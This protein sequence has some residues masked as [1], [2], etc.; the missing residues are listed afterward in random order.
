V[1]FGEWLQV[2]IGREAT[3][4]NTRRQDRTALVVAH[5][6]TSLQRLLDVTTL[7]ETDQRVQ[8]VF[9]QGPGVFAAAGVGELLEN[10]GAAVVPWQQATQTS[11]DVALASGYSGLAELHAPIVVLPHGAGYNKFVPPARTG[12]LPAR[13]P[14]YG[15]SAQHLVRDGHVI[16]S[17]V[18]LSHE[19]ECIALKVY[20]PEA[21]PAAFV[22][23]DP[24]FDRLLLSKSKRADYRRRLG[25]EDGQE[26]LVLSS[27]WGPDSLYGASTDV[28]DRVAQEAVAR[29]VA[30]A[31][32]LHPNVWF[33]HSPWQVHAWFRRHHEAGMRLI[34]PYLDWRSYLLCAD[35][36]VGDHGSVSLYAMTVG[37]PQLRTDFPRDVLVPGSAMELLCTAVPVVQPRIPLYEQLTRA[38]SAIGKSLRSA[39]IE[40]A[41]SQPG[42]S[43]KL[44]R[45]LIYQHMELDEPAHPATFDVVPPPTSC[46]NC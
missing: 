44:L 23:G 45:A 27:T 36:F 25:V 6:V 3:R 37:M 19:D 42:V 5:S 30:V 43:A 38:R 28:L 22:A 10:L 33:G 1:T 11:F 14:V 8:T 7:F 16:P 46:F 34:A 29:D 40:R 17:T 9:T 13:L 24:C 41:T 18:V 15:I 12:A 39:I 4:W 21:L 31:V 32:L 26:L 2:P 20:C 35:W